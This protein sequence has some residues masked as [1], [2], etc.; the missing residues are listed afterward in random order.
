MTSRQ[1]EEPKEGGNDKG[2]GSDRDNRSNSYPYGFS[3]LLL[4]T[5]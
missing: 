1:G 2:A 3:S 5:G 4:S